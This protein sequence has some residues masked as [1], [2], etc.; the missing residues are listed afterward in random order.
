MLEEIDRIPA[1][2]NQR[3]SNFG[4]PRR[5]RVRRMK[6]LSIISLCILFL[7]PVLYATPYE[8]LVVDIARTGNLGKIE[9]F[10]KAAAKFNALQHKGYFAA[11]PYF[12]VLRMANGRTYFVFGFNGD[13]QG[14]R[15]ENYPGTKKNLHRLKSVGTKKYP[16]LH[17]VPVE[18][19]RGLLVA[20]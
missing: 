8:V 4:F 16:N 20:P 11:K 17:W 15:R 1:I 5:V 14:I 19:I 2:F 13:I 6:I 3:Y 7:T 10:E 18:K 9:E 12:N